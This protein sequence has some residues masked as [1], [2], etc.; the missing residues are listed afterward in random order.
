MYCL[1]CITI[2]C[3]VILKNPSILFLFH[4]LFNY[5]LSKIDFKMKIFVQMNNLDKKGIRLKP[6]AYYLE[7]WVMFR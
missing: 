5:F 4:Y 6:Q 2:L 3:D 7:V 1:C